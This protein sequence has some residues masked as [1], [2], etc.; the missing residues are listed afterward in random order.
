MAVAV[1]GA[2]GK[3]AAE[4]R[5]IDANAA[6][7]GDREEIVEDF[8]LGMEGSILQTGELSGE[9]DVVDIFEETEDGEVV[10]ATDI[11][12]EKEVVIGASGLREGIFPRGTLRRIL[13]WVDE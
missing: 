12:A 8:F 4:T 2:F 7:I 10:I 3:L 13:T 9:E 6:E 11:E 1:D 5:L